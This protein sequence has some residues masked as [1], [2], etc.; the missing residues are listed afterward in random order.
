MRRDHDI[1]VRVT[2]EEYENIKLS[3]EMVDMQ[4]A[5]YIRKVAQNPTIVR[6]DYSAIR[7][8]TKQ[9][10]NIQRSINMLIY[11]FYINNDYLPK[12]IEAIV[13]YMKQ[14]WETENKLLEEVRKQ[15]IKAEKQGRGGFKNG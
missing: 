14:V 12:E 7:A 8:H 1:R 11:T 9:L 10:G 2:E 13:S 3:A 15:W 4:V 5:P 6:F